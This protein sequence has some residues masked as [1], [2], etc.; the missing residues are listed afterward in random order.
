MGLNPF[1]PVFST[2]FPTVFSSSPFLLMVSSVLS[3]IKLFIPFL[4]VSLFSL[5]AI[6]FDVKERRIPNNLNYLLLLSSI[7]ISVFSSIFSATYI[8]FLLLSLLFSYLLFKL[9]VW[10]GGDAK[11]FWALS[12]AFPLFADY[13]YYSFL[14]IFLNSA[15]MLALGLLV[16]HFKQLVKLRRNVFKIELIEASLLNSL[17]S[18]PLFLLASRLDLLLA[19]VFLVVA[20]FFL[21]PLLKKPNP[22]PFLLFFAGLLLDFNST[23][24]VFPLVFASIITLAFLKNVLKVFSSRVLV[25]WVALRDLRKGMVPAETVYLEKGRVMKWTMAEALG[26]L[27]RGRGFFLPRNKIVVDSLNAAGISGKE[28]KELK[29]LGALK[30]L[31]VRETIA[32]APVLF[33]GF[34][35]SVFW[36]VV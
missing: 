19:L 4:V 6:Y 8:L 3:S 9:G 25:K 23:I 16:I 14:S 35:L 11:F 5:A 20:G 29:K 32:F 22:V 27:V 26:S 13:N 28:I 7:F 1:C 10:G 24:S 34:V 12:A 31:G 36:K 30:Y 18:T 2:P 17:L 33:L 21:N 15:F